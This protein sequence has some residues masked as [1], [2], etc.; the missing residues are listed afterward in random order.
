MDVFEENGAYE[1]SPR[2]RKG[3]LHRG[4]VHATT[5][6]PFRPL[7][8]HAARVI[9][10]RKTE[11]W[12]RQ[13]CLP[14]SKYFG[15]IWK[16]P[17]VLSKSIIQSRFYRN[18]SR[19]RNRSDRIC[20]MPATVWRRIAAKT[21]TVAD[22]CRDGGTPPE[23]LDSCRHFDIGE[24]PIIKNSHERS[25]GRFRIWGSRKT[26]HSF[27]IPRAIGMVLSRIRDYRNGAPR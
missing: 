3:G 26:L 16:S 12:G 10:V 7:R 22:D 4:C 25:A 27:G 5:I 9:R 8:R 17:Y 2:S 21:R 18:G 13:P 1:K 19:I 23:S 11:D 6:P 20:G 24:L 15:R 14:P